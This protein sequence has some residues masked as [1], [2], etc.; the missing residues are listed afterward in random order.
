M[1]VQGGFILGFDSD[2]DTIFDTLIRFIQQSRI[3]VAMVGLLNA[4]R[5]TRLYKRMEKEQRLLSDFSG[6]NTDYS[7]NFTPKMARDKLVSGYKKVVG[8]IYGPESYYRRVMRYLDAEGEQ[9]QKPVKIH[10]ADIA[11]FVKSI[12]RLGIAGEERRWFWRLVLHTLRHNP[13]QLHKARHLCDIRAP[14][15]E[16][17]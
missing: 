9:P 7:M 4:P 6:D 10:P 13:S 16:G 5:G 2:P 3:V 11:S 8:S 14:L 12:F 1:E 17:V 15:Q